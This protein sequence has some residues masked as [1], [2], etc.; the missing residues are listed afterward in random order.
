MSDGNIAVEPVNVSAPEAVVTDTVEAV[1]A[2]PEGTAVENPVSETVENDT[3]G[4]TSIFENSK[5]ENTDENTPANDDINYGFDNFESYKGNEEYFSN[6]NKS[7]AGMGISQEQANKL[8]E[9]GDEILNP[10]INHYEEKLKENSPEAVENRINEELKTFSAEDQ[11]DLKEVN[12]MLANAFDNETEF[13]TFAKGFQT[14]ESFLLLKKFITSISGGTNENSAMLN[15]KGSNQG[16]MTMAT[17]NE[18][19]DRILNGD[20]S[21]I[22]SKKAELRKRARETGSPEVLELIKDF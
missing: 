6:L 3:D 2:E 18:E 14:R 22:N 13:E 11:A 16:E 7:F 5:T 20:V 19:F 1:Q 21:E 15:H 10:I 8:V 4:K 9:L 17:F 12:G